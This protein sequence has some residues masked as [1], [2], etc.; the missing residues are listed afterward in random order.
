MHGV[1]G[2]NNPVYKYTDM[3]TKEYGELLDSLRFVQLYGEIE[4]AY[5]L[6]VFNYRDY[7]LNNFSTIL[8]NVLTT[9]G[10]DLLLSSKNGI[11]RHISNILTS[12]YLYTSLL[13]IK[14][15]NDK[16][17]DY[18]WSN[19]D[20]KEQIY[21][22]KSEFKSITNSY[23]QSCYQYTFLSALRNKVN[24][25]GTLRKTTRSGIAWSIDYESMD[26]DGAE[27]SPV[28]DKRYS[29]FDQKITKDEA[30]NIID[31]S[32][33]YSSIE[34]TVP[35]SFYL[36]E[37]MRIYI[38]LLSKAHSKLRKYSEVTLINARELARSHLDS[39]EGY[40][41]ADVIKY[42]DD[43]ECETTFI[44]TPSSDSLVTAAAVKSPL[45]LERY[46][47]P[48]EPIAVPEGSEYS[49]TLR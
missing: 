37:A 28:K 43:K 44:G 22:L 5:E 41:R 47:M 8:T 34:E 11:D 45:H 14:R 19:S 36:R 9:T 26:S 46:A 35:D 4:K 10:R 25:G 40:I 13:R 31:N 30:Q 16:L 7:E 12:T 3:C 6:I 32:S 20:E 21:M 33:H 38:D 24:H 15:K 29:I 27:G 48:G 23:H 49:I 18:S 2:E 42:V 39:K 17:N 1:N